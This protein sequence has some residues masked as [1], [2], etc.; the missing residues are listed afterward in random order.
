MPQPPKK[1]P[2]RKT[3]AR[4]EKSPMGRA[5][6]LYQKGKTFREIGERL[7]ISAS[8]ARRWIKKGTIAPGDLVLEEI[9]AP[10]VIRSFDGQIPS[11]PIV[12]YVHFGPTHGLCSA[13][14]K[15]A[16]CRE[17]SPKNEPDIA[18]GG[19]YGQEVVDLQGKIQKLKADEAREFKA[20]E[21]VI[22]VAGRP[23]RVGFVERVLR[24]LR[25]K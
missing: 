3:Q 1:R 14:G 17:C 4:R 21:E 19:R 16:D 7:G 13:P 11:D 25:F 5:I 22:S 9:R 8:T 15:I 10:E 6:E 18:C 23:G 2:I 12:G 24:A 20:A